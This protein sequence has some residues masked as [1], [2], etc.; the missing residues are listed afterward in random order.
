MT[1]DLLGHEWAATLLQQHILR[2]QT[3]QAYL[4]T[5]PPGVGRRT[6]ALRFARALNCLQPPAPGESCGVCRICKQI[7]RMQSADLSMIVPDPETGSIKIDSVRELQHTLSLSP[8]EARWRVALLLKAHNATAEAQNALLKTLEEPNARVILLVTADAAESLLPTI[9]SRC[10]IIRLRPLPVDRLAEDLR[11]RFKIPPADARRLAHLANGCPGHAL[12]LHQDPEIEERHNERIDDL[13]SLLNAPLHTRFA[14]AESNTRGKDPKKTRELV[15]QMLRAWLLL[16]RDIFLA[17]SE[18]NTPLT[19]IKYEENI[20]QIAQK[21]GPLAARK[22]VSALEKA[23]VDLDGNAN[24]QLLM[25]ILLL[26][27]AE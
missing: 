11:E 26:D 7:E 3:R 14:F 8:Y 1:W 4:F 16:W 18:T 13:L 9:A 19:N 21:I 23:L 27:L 6:L 20:R 15:R 24:L 22:G 17:S 5:G 25:E 12:T 2:E 10:E